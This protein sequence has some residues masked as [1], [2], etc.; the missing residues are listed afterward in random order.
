LE[1]LE[2]EEATLTE[3]EEQEILKS[4]AEVVCELSSYLLPL[5]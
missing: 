2:D 1:E 3:Q 5:R 4:L